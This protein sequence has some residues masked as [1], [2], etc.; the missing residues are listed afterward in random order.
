M[1]FKI[2]LNRKTSFALM[3]SELDYVVLVM[4]FPDLWDLHKSFKIDC[5]NRLICFRQR[6]AIEWFMGDIPEV[7]KIHKFI[8]DTHKSYLIMQCSSVL[9]AEA[10]A[11]ILM[12]A[13]YKFCESTDLPG[14]E[15]IEIEDKKV[16]LMNYIHD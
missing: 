10:L 15:F 5:N 9:E 3:T 14:L 1:N 8:K 6:N 4:N 13:P 11:K 7:E 12:E 2:L 16:L